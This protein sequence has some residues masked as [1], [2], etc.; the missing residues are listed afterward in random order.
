MSF[1]NIMI[2]S[3]DMN[4]NCINIAISGLGLLTIED[5]KKRLIK[6]LPDSLT[7]NWTNI[8]DTQLNCLL[9]NEDFFDNS[10]IQRIITEKK[11]PYLKVSKLNESKDPALLCTPITDETTLDQLVETCVQKY[12]LHKVAPLALDDACQNKIDY[13]FFNQIYKEYSRKLLLEDQY[14]SIAVLDHHAHHAWPNS[15]RH[16]FH[17]DDSIHY[18]DATTS[19]LVKISRKLQKNLE[20]WLFEFIWNSP[21]FI[22]YPDEAA[23]FKLNFWPQPTANQQKCIL[24]LSAAFIL[25][26][27]ISQVAEKLNLPLNTV[28]KFIVAN[29]A[30][31][32]AEKIS[33]KEIQF[34]QQKNQSSNTNDVQQTQS[35]FQKL[36]RRF[37]F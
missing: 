25:G 12:Q 33:I 7:I 32:N 15:N 26:A 21:S 36:K 22:Q 37:G 16:S 14:G 8:S 1:L 34:A 19:D 6:K 9:I 18:L 23:C 28:Q 31:K 35:F 30:I 24:Q 29:Q 11:I 2:K 4:N 3:V 17:S 5:I 13:Q 20:N 27:Q 10:H